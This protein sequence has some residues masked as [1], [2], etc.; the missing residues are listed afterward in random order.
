MVDDRLRDLIHYVCWKCEDPSKLGVTKLYK[1]LWFSDTW[2]Y[3]LHGRPITGAEYV[4]R[5]FGPAPRRGLPAIE[6]LKRDGRLVEPARQGIPFER[7]DLIAVVVPDTSGF[8]PAEL[9]IVDTVIKEICDNY[10]AAG[11]SELSHDIV[12][13]V[14]QM[15]EVIPVFAVLASVPGEI[16]D[17]D[18]QWANDVIANKSP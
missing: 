8:S 13:D 10:T 14:A 7:R 5:E 16:T 4:K 15:G 6:E 9:M 2:H 11:I 3:R 18:M 1:I 17:A 12:W